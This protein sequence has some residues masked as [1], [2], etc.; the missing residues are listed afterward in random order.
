MGLAG[1]TAAKAVL[2]RHPTKLNSHSFPHCFRF[3]EHREAWLAG[4]LAGLEEGRGPYDYLKRL[5]DV[6]PSLQSI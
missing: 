1:L 6:R 3:L 4:L 2:L 5:T